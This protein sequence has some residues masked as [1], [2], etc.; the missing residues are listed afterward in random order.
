ME[1]R[2]GNRKPGTEGGEPGSSRRGRKGEG[3]GEKDE[4]PGI[5]SFGEGGGRHGGEQGNRTGHRSGP[6]AGRGGRGGDQPQSGERTGDHRENSR[7]GPEHH[8]H[9]RGYG[10]EGRDRKP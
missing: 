8:A 6:R 9:S 2:R 4:R 3:T 7:P 5:R 10:P 1:N